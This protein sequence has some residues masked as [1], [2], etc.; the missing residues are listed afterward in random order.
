MLNLWVISLTVDS[1]SLE[2]PEIYDAKIL[3]LIYRISLSR[4][5]HEGRKTTLLKSY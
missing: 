1:M 4:E 3:L 5:F 2:L